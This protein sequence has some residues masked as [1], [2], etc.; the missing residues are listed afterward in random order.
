MA[1]SHSFLQIST[2]SVSLLPLILTGS[3]RCLSVGGLLRPA[4]YLYERLSFWD[5][6]FE[7]EEA[8][9][10]PVTVRMLS[11]KEENR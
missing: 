4:L 2:H 8:E 9:K 11:Q 1:V 3:M 10:G 5:S 6:L 7:L